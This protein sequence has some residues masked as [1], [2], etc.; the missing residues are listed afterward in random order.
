MHTSNSNHGSTGPRT[1][2]GKAISRENAV[3]HALCGQ[4][5]RLLASESGDLFQALFNALYAEHQPVTQTEVI[6]VVR[7]A[8][9]HWMGQR[10][11]RLATDALEAGDDKRFN[12]MARYQTTHDRAFAATLKQ[13]TAMQNARKAEEHGETELRI[14]ERVAVQNQKTLRNHAAMLRMD[15]APELLNRHHFKPERRPATA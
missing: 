2:E 14:A 9:S 15:S 6:L 4:S 5:F 3:R 8:Q 12:T 7:M 1:S 13:L 11:L 10:A